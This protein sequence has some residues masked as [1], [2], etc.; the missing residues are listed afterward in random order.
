[1]KATIRLTLLTVLLLACNLASPT[2]APRPVC[3]PPPCQPDEVY[4]CPDEC[5]GGCGTICA[6]PTPAAETPVDSIPL[7]DG[8]A[9]TVSYPPELIEDGGGWMVFFHAESTKEAYVSIQARRE[10]GATAEAAADALV[11][12]FT[13]HGGLPNYEP[14]TVTDLLGETLT[15]AGT[16]LSAGGEHFRLL[17]VVRPETLLGNMLPDDVVY[18]IVARAPE[19]DW[20]QWEPFFDIIFRT[21]QP[22]DCGG[23]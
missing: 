1:M 5:P 16:E 6:T 9:F 13:G 4:Y 7:Y 15:G 11:A 10:T 18:E 19:P 20:P 3:T 12:Q 23:V 14:V 8:C 17:V 22:R 2:V 21:F